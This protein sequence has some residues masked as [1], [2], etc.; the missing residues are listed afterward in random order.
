VEANQN[1]TWNGSDPIFLEE[2]C[3]DEEEEEFK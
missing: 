2:V 3:Q 1:L